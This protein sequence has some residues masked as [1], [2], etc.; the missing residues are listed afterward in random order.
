MIKATDM[1]KYTFSRL[2]IAIPTFAAVLFI[3]FTLTVLSPFDPVT[4]MMQQYEGTLD[5]LQQQEIVQRIRDQYGLDDSFLIQFTKYVQRLL[6]GD[7]GISVNGQRDVL[8]TIV[9]TF[10]ISLQLGL[11]GGLLTALVGIPLGALAALKQNTW[12]DYSIVGGSLLFR[13]LPVF[14]LAPLLLVLFVLILGVMK[15]PR[16]WDGLFQT[17]TI[18]PIFILMLGPLPVVIRQTRQAVLEI[19]SQDYIRTAK[20]KGLAM[21]LIIV[22]HILRNALI[23]VVTTL[24]FIIEG[25]IVG[26]IFLENIFAI[27]GF[28]AVA[29]NAFRGFDYPMI[30]G[31]T[32]LT[33]VMIILTN[34]LVDLVYP[35]LDPRIKLE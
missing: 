3:T 22:R 17:K 10:P 5:A 9:T 13:S 14:V 20:M 32:M 24:G 7:L 8:R 12:M 4:I 27:P 11:A 18:L 21:W 16:G 28:G 29:E 26:S 6:Q 1:L 23:P 30:L 33:S 15:V 25:L 2:L 19:F 31:V 34:L 35:F